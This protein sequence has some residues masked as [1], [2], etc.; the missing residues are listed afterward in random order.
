MILQEIKNIKSR[1]KELREFG[2]VVGVV[3]GL[4][5]G[6]FWWKGKDHY[7]FLL[8]VSIALVILGL[9]APVL[10]KPLHKI[11]MAFAIILGWIMTRIILSILFY[12]VITPIGLLNRLSGK[13]MLD[14]K[15]D[16]NKN[17]YWTPRQ[18]GA[19]DKVSYEKQ[20]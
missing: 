3:F 2:V 14:L 15:F 10:L 13:D 9:I 8:T 11:W 5:G 6:L 18:Q 1:K 17:S 19:F 16:K 7:F 4:F 12:L 20:F